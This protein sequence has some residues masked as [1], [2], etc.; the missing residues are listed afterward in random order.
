[1]TIW[2]AGNPTQHKSKKINTDTN[3]TFPFLDMEF[4]WNEDNNL[5]YRVHIKE[6]QE[7]KY[8]NKGSSHP[9]A[10][11][12]AIYMGVS[13][14]LSKLTSVTAKTVDKKLDELYPRH[15]EALFTA[16][17]HPGGY[18]TLGKTAKWAEEVDGNNEKRKKHLKQFSRQTFFPVA[19]HT[20]FYKP[21]S[22]TIMEARNRHNVKYIRPSV[23]Y[24]KF[25]NVK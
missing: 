10:C 8:L 13:K 7:I 16:G 12:K 21:M 14:R 20:N 22:A 24:H 18:P 15:A 25:P 6:N 23:S 19:Y 4:Y 9:K 1:M 17:L 3:K 5:N 2:D 11:F